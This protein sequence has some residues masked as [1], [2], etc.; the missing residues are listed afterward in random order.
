MLS[1]TRPH[2]PSSPLWT[3]WF[4]AHPG[5]S[6]NPCATTA[7]LDVAGTYAAGGVPAITTG[8]YDLDSFCTGGA[9]CPGSLVQQCGFAKSPGVLDVN[10]LRCEP[11]LLRAESCCTR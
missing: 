10:N 1:R 3:S 8:S 6:A 9:A 11:A 5:T 4:D 2:R 7:T